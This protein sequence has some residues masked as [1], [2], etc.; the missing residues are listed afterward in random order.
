MSRQSDPTPV[1]SYCQANTIG[2]I[3]MDAQPDMRCKHVKRNAKQELR[4]GEGSINGVADSDS[5]NA[6][7]VA[8]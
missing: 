3:P 5:F 7:V 4:G 8:T 2:N 1:V 6:L